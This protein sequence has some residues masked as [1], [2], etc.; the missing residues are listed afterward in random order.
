MKFAKTNEKTSDKKMFWHTLVLNSWPLAC[1]SKECPPGHAP[2]LDMWWFHL[3]IYWVCFKNWNQGKNKSE[4]KRGVPCGSNP[5][6]CEPKPY[7]A[8]PC[9]WG[10]CFIRDIKYNQWNILSAKFWKKI[11]PLHLL[12]WTENKLPWLKIRIPS[13]LNQIKKFKHESCL[14]FHHEFNHVNY[15]S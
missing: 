4:N 7:N 8:L 3:K 11:F 2:G 9:H 10:G 6:P 1:N 15:E 13:F 5:R 14:V 12:P